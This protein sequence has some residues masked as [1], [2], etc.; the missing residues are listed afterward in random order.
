MREIKRIVY[1][2]NNILPTV[3]E[4]V[5]PPF[6]HAACLAVLDDVCAGGNPFFVVDGASSSS[7]FLFLGAGMGRATDEEP[8]DSA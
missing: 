6:V 1:L 2:E 7:R 5:T 4:V 8:E 3:A